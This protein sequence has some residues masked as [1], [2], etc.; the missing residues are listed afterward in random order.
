MLSSAPSISFCQ[1]TCITSSFVTD[2]HEKVIFPPAWTDCTFLCSTCTE[3]GEEEGTTFSIFHC[4]T[5]AH[6]STCF[7]PQPSPLEGFPVPAARG[8][9]KA[10]LKWVAIGVWLKVAPLTPLPMKYFS[11]SV[12]VLLLGISREK[13]KIITP[14]PIHCHIGEKIQRD[15][16]V[17]EC[18]QV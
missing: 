1:V 4:P 16:Q 17:S 2:W 12:L 13:G 10:Q 15:G 8:K 6:T 18:S 7:A 14:L 9:L 11:C 3:P 5:A